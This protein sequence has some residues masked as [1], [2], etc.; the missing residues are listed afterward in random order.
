MSAVFGG[1][2]PDIEDHRTSHA[3]TLT[4]S[5]VEIVHGLD[6][7]AP[8]TKRLRRSCEIDSTEIHTV[9]RISPI[10]LHNPDQTQA[11]IEPFSLS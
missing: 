3:Q 11:G 9:V 4:D 2:D 6:A 7:S 5:H 10:L 1:I 8:C